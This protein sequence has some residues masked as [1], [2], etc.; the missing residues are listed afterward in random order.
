MM[1]RSKSKMLMLAQKK[2]PKLQ[3]CR[4]CHLR[5]SKCDRG[6]P[7]SRCVDAGREYTYDKVVVKGRGHHSLQQPRPN[8]TLPTAPLH[9]WRDF[10]GPFVY[11]PINASGTPFSWPPS[12]GM[13][14]SL[15]HW[16]SFATAETH[17]GNAGDDD[18]KEN[19]EEMSEGDEEEE[20]DDDDDVRE[21]EGHND[22]DE[23]ASK[24]KWGFGRPEYKATK[25]SCESG[26]AGKSSATRQL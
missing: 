4:E 5:S 13:P 22:N 1:T 25:R 18:T 2:M 16:S 11:T 14:S 7:C 24:K 19:D 26:L 6:R 15:R 23:N 17:M 9:L 12:D 10:S 20:E 21:A 3:S 8:D